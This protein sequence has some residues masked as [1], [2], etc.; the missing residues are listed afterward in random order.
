MG[1]H[2]NVDPILEQ[3]KVISEG[4]AAYDKTAIAQAIIVSEIIKDTKIIIKE[5]YK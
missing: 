2:L 1:S 4:L 3:P 5:L